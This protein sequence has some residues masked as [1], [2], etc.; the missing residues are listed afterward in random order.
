MEGNTPLQLIQ[1]NRVS[2]IQT[3]WDQEVLGQVKCLDN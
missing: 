2:V 1:Y 3:N